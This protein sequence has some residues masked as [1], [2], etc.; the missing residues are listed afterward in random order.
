M[1][2]NWHKK[3]PPGERRVDLQAKLSLLMK[4]VL[5][6]TT[7][8]SGPLRDQRPITIQFAG[9]LA[10]LCQVNVT[11]DGVNTF[12]Y[13]ILTKRTSASESSG[14]V[15]LIVVAPIVPLFRKTGPVLHYR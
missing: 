6:N 8:R 15:N 7:F 3:Y 13:E 1:A 4:G 14:C 5:F 10:S 9:S 2:E 11:V 12:S